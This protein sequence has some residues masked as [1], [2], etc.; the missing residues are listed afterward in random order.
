METPSENSKL[1]WC[2]AELRILLQRLLDGNY[3]ITAEYI[4]DHVAHSGVD[5][6]INPELGKLAMEEFLAKESKN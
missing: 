2:E 1:K 3:Q 5:L 4:F 6:K